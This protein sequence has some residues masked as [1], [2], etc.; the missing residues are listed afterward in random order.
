CD[1]A[2]KV[3]EVLRQRA[4]EHLHATGHG[5][6]LRPPISAGE[7]PAGYDAQHGAASVT[8]FNA[9]LVRDEPSVLGLTAA[10][11]EPFEW[12]PH[13]HSKLWG[14]V[15]KDCPHRAALTRL[16]L[17]APHEPGVDS[18]ASGDRLPDLLRGR[19][20]HD[21]VGY[22]EVMAQLKPPSSRSGWSG[23]SW[24]PGS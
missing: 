4:A 1:P 24:P 21:L 23:R 3:C 11:G 10:V 14:I 9:K 18:W 8:C 16:D 2:R 13:G 19:V 7:E 17:A 20:E 5:L 22:L 15:A 12:F 6:I